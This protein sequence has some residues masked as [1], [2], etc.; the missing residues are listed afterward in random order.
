MN[1]KLLPGVG[2]RFVELSE[3]HQGAGGGILGIFMDDVTKF[4]VFSISGVND[5]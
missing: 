5:L 4:G 3:L 2:K 1:S